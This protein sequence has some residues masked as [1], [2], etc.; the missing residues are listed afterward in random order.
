MQEQHYTVTHHQVQG[1]IV[2][3]EFLWTPGIITIREQKIAVT[4][5]VKITNG[6]IIPGPLGRRLHI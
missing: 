4:S 5:E 3:C 1:V 2:L 6:F